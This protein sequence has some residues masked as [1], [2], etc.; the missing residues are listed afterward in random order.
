MPG[1][2][3]EAVPAATPQRSASAGLILPPIDQT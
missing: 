2:R 1:S 3:A